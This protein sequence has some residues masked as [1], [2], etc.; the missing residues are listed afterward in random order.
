MITELSRKEKLQNYRIILSQYTSCLHKWLVY[1]LVCLLLLR[2]FSGKFLNV[3][4]P[5]IKYPLW[6]PGPPGLPFYGNGLACL[7]NWLGMV[8]AGWL[9]FMRS[10]IFLQ[11]FPPFYL[12]S[13]LLIISSLSSH[14]RSWSYPGNFGIYSQLDRKSKTWF[15][16][17]LCVYVCWIKRDKILI[18][19][20]SPPKFRYFADQNGRTKVGLMKMNFDNF[21]IQ[22]WRSQTEL[23]K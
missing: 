12:G 10:E 20:L 3:C 9:C 7:P 16:T 13:L 6:Q 4:K 15:F 2:F 17:F 14:F 22:K 23:K 8:N 21:Q 19:Q 18:S 11:N 1:F 5:R